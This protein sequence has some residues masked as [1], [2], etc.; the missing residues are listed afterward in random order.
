MVFISSDRCWEQAHSKKERSSLQLLTS[1]R[2]IL[3]FGPLTSFVFILALQ[4]E[5]HLDQK[6]KLIKYSDFVNKELILFSM[7]DLQRS[8]L[9]MVDGLKPGLRKI[10]FYSF[11]QN[12]T[13]EVKV[14]QFS[15]YVSGNSAYH[16]GEQNL[17]GTIIG[18]AQDFIGNNNINLLLP[19]GQFGN[20][21]QGGKDHASAKYVYT[22]LS[23]ITRF[24]FPKED[25]CLLDYLNEDGQSIEP[26]WYMPS[27]PMVLINSSEVCANHVSGAKSILLKLKG[28]V[29]MCLL[30]S[31]LPLGNLPVEKVKFCTSYIFVQERLQIDRSKVSPLV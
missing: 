17:A 30:F 31:R 7:A 2:K 23:P 6:E 29:R 9:S 10:L 21:H 15:G 11:K 26:T 16:H 8:I 14:V 13:K 18:M 28:L 12:F 3:W 24:L 25:D 5:T 1:T 20:R 27:I 22:C 4:P 19:N